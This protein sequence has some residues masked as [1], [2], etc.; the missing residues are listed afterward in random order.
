MEG[1]IHA[2]LSS[3]GTP[4]GTD[5]VGIEVP[6]GGLRSE[7]L[8]RP[9]AV[10]MGRGKLH[11]LNEAIFNCRHRD[12]SFEKLLNLLRRDRLRATAESTAVNVYRERGWVVG[13][14][15]PDIED[16]LRVALLIDD[17]RMRGR[18]ASRSRFYLALASHIARESKTEE[19][20]GSAKGLNRSR[21]F[22]TVSTGI[23]SAQA[24]D[25]DEK[26]AIRYICCTV[27]S[28]RW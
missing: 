13:F 22:D 21:H 18:G 23:V 5:A 9:P 24:R 8:K 1:E 25:S 16:G 14:R 4:P 6:L 19:D 3:G 17:I 15:D 7:K 26:V 12:S 2:E 20:E 11:V 10:V 28:V 27:L